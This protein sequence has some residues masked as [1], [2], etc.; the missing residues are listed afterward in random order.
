MELTEVGARW[1]A[2][3][4]NPGIL[5]NDHDSSVFYRPHACEHVKYALVITQEYTK[6]FR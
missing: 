4:Y 5:A 3:T 6:V 2:E 1:K